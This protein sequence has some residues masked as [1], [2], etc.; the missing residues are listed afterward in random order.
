M[1]IKDFNDQQLVDSLNRGDESSIA[2]IYDRYW[3]K[4]LSIAYNQTKDKAAAEEVVQEVLINLWDRRNKVKIDSLPNY[5]ATAVKYSVLNNIQREKRRSVIAE[6]IYAPSTK[7]FD[8]EEIFAR[9]L[10]DYINGIVETLPEKC[11]LVFKHS[12][13]QGKNIPQ[14][15]KELNIAEKT[16]EA[17]LT[18]AL[19]TIRHTLKST[20]IFT[21]LFL[22]ANHR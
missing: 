1:N 4:L 9:F 11:R 12:R 8:E 17:H 19:K 2:E 5:L 3:L 18:K 10:Q 7:S 13:E 15:A 16:V 21:L 22:L 14:I 6:E 20:G